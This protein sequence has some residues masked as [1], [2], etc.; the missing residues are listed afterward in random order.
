MY[1]ELQEQIWMLNKNAAS[2][3]IGTSMGEE[4]CLIL[5]QVSLKRNLQTD[6]CGQGED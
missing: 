5:G 1:P 3:T 4:I 2:T 6:I